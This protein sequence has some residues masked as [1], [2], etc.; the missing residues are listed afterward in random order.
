MQTDPSVKTPKFVV[1]GSVCLVVAA[2]YFGQEVLVP[3]A[4][5]AL[6]S[7]LLAPLVKRLERFRCPRS[8]AVVITVLIA[9][10]LLFAIGWV[11]Y[12]QL[13]DLNKD[14]DTYKAHVMAKVQAMRAKGGILNMVHSAGAEVSQVLN[15][16]TTAPTKTTST[17]EE[18]TPMAFNT[19]NQSSPFDLL[20]PIGVFL[21]GP[22]GTAFIVTVFTIFMLLQREDLRD[23]LIRLVGRNQLTLT[24]KALDDA[25]ERV[26]RYL[27][28]QSVINSAVGVAI[29][30]LLWGV[31]KLNGIAFP[32]VA[33]WA[34]MAALLRFIPYV[35][36]WVAA[37]TPLLLALA[38]YPGAKAAVET[39][40]CFAAVE[41]VTGNAIEPM[42]L[43]S[44][45]GIATLAVLV[46]AAFWT[47]LWGPVGLLLS[48]PLTVCLVVMGK[49]V[50]QLEF[51]TILLAEEPALS[52]PDRIYQRLLAFDQEEAED[53]VEEYA[54]KM[55]IDQVYDTVLV[56]ALST[57]EMDA[58]RGN[59]TRDQLTL[60]QR[61]VRE[62]VEELRDRQRSAPKDE[63]AAELLPDPKTMLPKGCS[64]N[65]VCLPANGESDEIAGLMLAHLLEIRGYCVTVASVSQLASEMVQTVGD[66][67]AD[68]VCVSALPP[69]AVTHARYLC[70]RLQAQLPDLQLVVG[71]WASG[72]NLKRAMD[73][74]STVR[75][76]RMS[77][78][79]IRAVDEIQQLAQ[80]RIL[81]PE[82]DSHPTDLAASATS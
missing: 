62:M 57:A 6:L 26:S 3:L 79:F 52:P 16:P 20:K 9:F 15:T 58:H 72:G 41:G 33:L 63:K 28:M 13:G 76:V 2:L 74:I 17:S 59:L 12:D 37:V 51:L 48:T 21:L 31:G 22:M 32:A 60:I 14:M 1:L 29:L 73:R 24:T 18:P 77:D 68:V 82:A 23:R 42:L 65:V 40:L 11:V 45:T 25:A 7:F 71:L 69:A 67:R 80:P 55:P 49:Y 39:L 44:S 36:I 43:G 19:A 66:S 78:T 35:G 54:K 64:V 5:A 47:W 81:N 34:M 8:L 50:P 61:G 38:V 70:K 56:P 10:G 4:L 53:L 30:I 46:A 27:L 75:S